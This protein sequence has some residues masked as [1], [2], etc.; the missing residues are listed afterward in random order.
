[1]RRCQLYI[2]LFVGRRANFSPFVYNYNIRGTRGRKEQD[3]E[4][5]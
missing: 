4:K 2:D 3:Y 1:M 5:Q